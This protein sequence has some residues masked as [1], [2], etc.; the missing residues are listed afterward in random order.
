MVIQYRLFLGFEQWLKAQEVLLFNNPMINSFDVT[1]V[2]LYGPAGHPISFA[3]AIVITSLPFLMRRPIAAL[4]SQ[5]PLQVGANSKGAVLLLCVI[6][7]TRIMWPTLMRMA[8]GRRVAL[9]AGTWTAI[10]AVGIYI[11]TQHG[12]YHVLGLSGG[13][14]AFLANPLGNGVGTGGNL[15]DPGLVGGVDF[16]KAQRWGLSRGIESAIG[17]LLDQIG[18]FSFFYFILLYRVIRRLFA[19]ADMVG[20]VLGAA[21]M[22][23]FANGFLQEEALFSPSSVGLL[24][25]LVALVLRESPVGPV[26]A[27]VQRDRTAVAFSEG[28]RLGARGS[29]G[30][31]KR[32]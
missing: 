18:V 26:G 23:L 25:F 16:L 29:C 31:V 13:L 30:G 12:D 1:A 6:A 21:A 15:S 5:A 11:G 2:R 7:A 9:L 27:R 3:Y 20:T 19:R 14:R 4:L 28:R 32:R 24:F 8:V 17:V 10:T 22:G